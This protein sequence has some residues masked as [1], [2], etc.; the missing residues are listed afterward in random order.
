MTRFA[1]I[2][3]LLIEIDLKDIKKVMEIKKQYSTFHIFSTRC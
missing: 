2:V 3:R 1:V